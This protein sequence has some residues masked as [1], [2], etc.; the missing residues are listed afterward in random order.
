VQV[1]IK[2]RFPVL[3]YF[4]RILSKRV[5]I[6]HTHGSAVSHVFTL[7]ISVLYVH[8]THNLSY[9]DSALTCQTSN[10]FYKIISFKHEYKIALDFKM[11]V[12]LS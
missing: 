1:P 5:E 4:M 6:P 7:N 10:E 11:T 9:A 8:I 2:S 12:T 3:L